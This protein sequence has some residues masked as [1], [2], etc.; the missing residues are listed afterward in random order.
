M[1][2]FKNVR[3]KMGLF[4][5]SLFLFTTN[6][7]A[8]TATK[9]TGYFCTGTAPNDLTSFKYTRE[10]KTE[11]AGVFVT[12]YKISSLR[13]G[14]YLNIKATHYKTENK[15]VV[16]ID[17]ITV[18]EQFGHISTE[19]ITYDEPTLKTFGRANV[20][21]ANGM[22][23]QG[24]LP[25]DLGLKFINQKFETIKIVHVKKGGNMNS[26]KWYILDEKN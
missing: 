18:N 3:K 21:K 9:Y 23:P 24:R 13:D 6:I 14:Y 5:F 26:M 8:Q 20:F 16:D 7:F 2:Q 12:L 25:N 1:K 15:I 19:E 17:D 10:Y 4:A 22:D 11:S